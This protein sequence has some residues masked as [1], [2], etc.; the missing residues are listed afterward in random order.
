LNLSDDRYDVVRDEL[1]RDGLVEKYRCAGGGLRLT[2]KGK[3]AAS[4]SSASATEESEDAWPT[5]TGFFV[6]ASGHVLTN[7]HVVDGFDLV[8][9]CLEGGAP[10]LARVVARD[11]ENDLALLE[12]DYQPKTLPVFRRDVEVGEDVATYGF[13]LLDYL[14]KTGTFTTGTVSANIVRDNT[15]LLQIQA[16]VQPGN[17]GGPLFDQSGN[18]VG[19]VVSKLDALDLAM[20]TRDIPQLVNFAIKSDVALSF[21]NSNRVKVSTAAG[22]STRR[23]WP[24]ITSQARLI[25]ALIECNVVENEG[26]PQDYAEALKRLRRAADR[27]DA[28]AQ[29]ALGVLYANGE[30]VPQDE[31]EAA[32]WFRR[33]ADQ[34]HAVAQSN[35]GAMYAAGKGVSQNATEA[36]RWCRSAAEQGDAAAQFNLGIMYD[37]GEGVPQ[38]DAEAAKWFRRAADQGIAGAQFNLAAMYDEGRGVPQDD[39]DAVK[40]YRRAADQGIAEAQYDLGVMYDEGQGVPQD[41]AEAVKW[42]R[43]AADQG[44]TSA[45]YNLGNMYAE[46]RGVPRGSGE[47]VKWYRLAA[48]E[49]H[50][51]AQSNLG[52]MYAE[53]RGVPQDD[54]EAVKWFRRAVDQGNAAAQSNLGFM[55][56]EGR[57]VPRDDAEA[58]KWY[59][60]AADQGDAEAQAAYE[61]LTKRTETKAEREEQEHPGKETVRRETWPAASYPVIETI[62]RVLRAAGETFDGLTLTNT[63]TYFTAHISGE[64]SR[65][66]TDWC[67]WPIG[68]F[69]LTEIREPRSSYGTVGSVAFRASNSSNTTRAMAAGTS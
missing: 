46:G 53:G 42:Y 61:M 18:V 8:Q 62:N 25:A 37:N 28:D 64:G 57:G 59:R 44:F 50:A 58:V 67:F 35:L 7:A 26:V 48:D 39:A 5:G 45:Q 47:A 65:T 55:Y 66:R 63:K 54:V 31:A 68:E 29:S 33:A 40:W 13:P 60:R 69:F 15:N 43:L 21:L 34:G 20:V 1:L 23:S 3:K 41:D 16:P 36:A 32:K 14:G 22:A 9:V 12:T 2:R 49:G 6:S 17:S 51:A 52:R 27:G 38:D 10:H 19:V 4:Q 30:G 11:S 56:G 24:E